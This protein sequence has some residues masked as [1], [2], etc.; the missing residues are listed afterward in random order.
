MGDGNRRQ[1][2]TKPA[3]QSMMR[4]S[5]APSQIENIRRQSM[6]RS[7]LAPDQIENM[8][9]QSSIGA[10]M[11]QNGRVAPTG[12]QAR[13]KDPRPIEDKKY[14]E[15]TIRKIIDYLTNNS[16]PHHISPKILSQPTSKDFC[17]VTYFLIQ[18]VD[19]TYEFKLSPEEEIPKFFKQLRYPFA[20]NKSSLK[21]VGSKATWPQVLVALGWLVELLNYSEIAQQ[22]RYQLEEDMHEALFFDFLGLAYEQFL[23][24]KNSPYGE[25]ESKLSVLFADKNEVVKNQ[26]TEIAKENELLRQQILQLENEKKNYQQIELDIL[27]LQSDSQKF[28]TMVEQWQNHLEALQQRALNYNKILEEEQK[29]LEQAQS[30]Q[31]QIIQQLDKQEM[32]SEDVQKFY[33]E[34][35]Q[36]QKELE[37]IIGNHQTA[38]DQSLELEE[39]LQNLYNEIQPS[40]RLYNQLATELKLIPATGK[41]AFGFQFYEIQL[42]IQDLHDDEGTNA[43]ELNKE[44]RLNLL[45]LRE[46]FKQKVNE[47]DEKRIQLQ[48]QIEQEAEK[49]EDKTEELKQTQRKSDEL[50]NKIAV[51]KQQMTEE[52]EDYLR[53]TQQWKEKTAR[54][55]HSSQ[56][57]LN[58]SVACQQ[59][60]VKKFEEFEKTSLQARQLFTSEY[61]KLLT[62]I[63]NHKTYLKT[64][65]EKVA[66][67]VKHD[68]SIM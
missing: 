14:I 22:N 24:G 39:Q 54:L 32:K 21:S 3:R 36:Y 37:L 57:G 42:Q 48:H 23:Q 66:E 51:E 45:K 12:Q 64:R 10:N 44:I 53:I 58:K 52:F 27:A 56:E 60:A 34:R 7:S 28:Q 5:L 59:L 8:R 17:D 29:K 67:N 18:C 13:S 16:Y 26:T 62:L 43:M 38:R 33:T 55:E 35:T 61:Q 15:L 63:M 4:S 50:A 30:E 25:L 2:L 68:L 31:Q 11:F 65:L 9:R 49:V 47:S 19:P 46:H 6:V 41:Y 40:I 1:T 20:L